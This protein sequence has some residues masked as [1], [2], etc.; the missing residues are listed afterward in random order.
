MREDRIIE[1]KGV[2]IK[3]EWIV[4]D[5]ADL[6]EFGIF[7]RH[8]KPY[9]IDIQRGILYG[10]NMSEVL[11]TGISNSFQNETASYFVTSFNHLPHNPANWSH[12][13][14]D[15]LMKVVEKYGSIE[16]ADIAFAIDDYYAIQR[17]FNGGWNMWGCRA[18]LLFGDFE[19]GSDS[20][21]GIAL[22]D[23]PYDDEHMDEIEETLIGGVIKQAQKQVIEVIEK[24][25]EFAQFNMEKSKE[26]I[27]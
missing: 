27:R 20:I 13:K 21:W 11:E 15:I 17:F 3:I 16:K 9:S 2:Q 26:E 4:D 22:G 19:F 6:S 8:W 5:D 18:T 12:V 7:S 24:L 23:N 10:E 1:Y 14:D 25:K